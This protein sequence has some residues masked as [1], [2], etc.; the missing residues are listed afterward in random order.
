MS[1]IIFDCYIHAVNSS[2]ISIDLS[3]L[4]YADTYIY[5]IYN[6]ILDRNVGTV[7]LPSKTALSGRKKWIAIANVPSGSIVIDDGAARA[8]HQSNSLFASGIVS[9]KGDFERNA[10]VSIY[11][12][13]MADM[14]SI[15][16]ATGA[17]DADKTM[18]DEIPLSKSLS[19]S[20]S[21]RSSVNAAA[22]SP[23]CDEDSSSSSGGGVYAPKL[24]EIGRG[25][26]NFSSDELQLIKGKQ[27]SE[28]PSVLMN[29]YQ[30]LQSMHN[31]TSTTSSTT[32]T[33]EFM[34]SMDI[35]S[36]PS[37]L[38]LLA[39]LGCVI[40]RENLAIYDKTKP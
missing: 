28:I 13:S 9:V 1:C 27:S 34:T 20:S 25:L 3:I 33:N 6:I 21:K 17:D 12:T 37:H 29:Y 35:S 36:I 5:I 31:I 8:V 14:D 40:N 30:K 39:D 18:L 4:T 16:G 23:D 22:A 19:S 2:P 10:R 38:T 15:D 11:T 32:A 24:I 26:V 7:F